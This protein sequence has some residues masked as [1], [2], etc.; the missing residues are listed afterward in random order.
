MTFRWRA[1]DFLDKAPAHPSQRSTETSFCFL[2]CIQHYRVNL[3]ASPYAALPAEAPIREPSLLR[4]DRSVKQKQELWFTLTE[5]Y[6]L[7][8][9][10]I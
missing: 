6:L 7:T 3:K 4:A 8:V 9:Q 2:F 5:L 10:S 1:W